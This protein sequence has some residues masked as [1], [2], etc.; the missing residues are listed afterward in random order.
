MGGRLLDGRPVGV[1]RGNGSR[2]KISRVM[3][4]TQARYS[5]AEDGDDK[6]TCEW[7]LRD[8][9]RWRRL[10]SMGVHGLE[11]K[12]QPFARRKEKEIIEENHA[13]VMWDT[14]ERLE[15]NRGREMSRRLSG[16]WDERTLSSELF[17][18][19]PT[20]FKSFLHLLDGSSCLLASWTRARIKLHGGR[21]S[22]GG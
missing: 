3:D 16:S 1:E 5:L 14:S 2:M 7:S 8:L 9:I 18:L 12:V 10:H 6:S 15:G 11:D 22:T 13:G 21:G 20:S 19:G 17:T 4:V